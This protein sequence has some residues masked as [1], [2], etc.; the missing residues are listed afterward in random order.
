MKSIWMFNY[1]I[2]T[3]ESKQDMLRNLINMLKTSSPI[4]VCQTL[5]KILCYYDLLD[6]EM[7]NTLVGYIEKMKD[8]AFCRKCCK[9]FKWWD[10]LRKVV[11]DFE[12]MTRDDIYL[13]ECELCSSVAIIVP[14]HLSANSFLQ[15]P[16]DT[17]MVVSQLVAK[18]ISYEFIDNRIEKLNPVKLYSKIKSC[19][20]VVITST[21]Y[22]HIQNYFLIID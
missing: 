2:V 20:Y 13:S 10:N 1:D 18:N 11:Y 16:V 3:A 9:D 12:E 15:P 8:C 4:V 19:E 21:P 22:D 7:K 17:M 5:E 6:I 14:D